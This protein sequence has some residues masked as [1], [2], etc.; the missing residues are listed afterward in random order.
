MKVQLV[1]VEINH[2]RICLP[3][4]PFIC[5]KECHNMF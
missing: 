1:L 3:I 5:G 4:L 2:I